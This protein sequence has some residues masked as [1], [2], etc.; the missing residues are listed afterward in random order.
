MR[1][2]F[3]AIPLL[4]LGCAAPEHLSPIDLDAIA[5][6]VPG[7]FSSE[8]DLPERYADEIEAPFLALPE[9]SFTGVDDVSIHYRVVH[10]D[11]PVGSVVF[12]AG[13][14]EPILKHAENFWDLSAQGYN[15]YAL[16]LRGQ[17]ASG[18][19]LDNPQIQYVKFWDDY[20]QD[21]SAFVDTVVLPDDPGPLFLMAHSMGATSA[22][23]FLVERPEVFAGAAF[24]SPMIGIDTGA[25][26]AAVAQTLAAGVCD[27]SAGE[28]YTIGHGDYSD[29]YTLEESTVTHSQARFDFKMQIFD[30]Y[31][32]LRVGG[33]SW[34]W[35]CEG[36]AASEVLI[37]LGPDTPTRTL[38][39]EAEDELVVL[40]EAE[41]RWCE[42]APGCQLEV[43]PGSKHEIF[44]EVDEVRN[45][46]LAHT[47]RF[48]DAVRELP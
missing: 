9:G 27:W 39:F 13:R 18:R 17:G 11:D 1:L 4:A 8:A 3:P 5:S 44:S 37:G 38:V 30:D 6:P 15:V 2:M 26:P 40:P 19:M 33:V 36:L 10:A 24:S 48:F 45:E 43:L 21:L 12:L 20:V 28:G 34:R 42:E 32:E 14:T 35:L 46:A 29:D 16:D 31:P 7:D 25:F 47:V 22:G 23:L 41:E